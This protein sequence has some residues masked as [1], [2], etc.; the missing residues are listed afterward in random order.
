MYGFSLEGLRHRAAV[1]GE[2]LTIE[3][4]GPGGQNCFVSISS[5][6]T[7]ID[8]SS[9][10]HVLISELPPALKQ[11]LFPDNLKRSFSSYG[12]IYYQ[13]FGKNDG[14]KIYGIQIEHA[15]F[16]LQ[17]SMIPRGARIKVISLPEH[18]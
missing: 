6:S 2:D 12:G 11:R 16:G 7:I 17:L 1:A 14:T 4:I 5:L 10:T 15:D 8:V 3:P 13:V 18:S 9:G